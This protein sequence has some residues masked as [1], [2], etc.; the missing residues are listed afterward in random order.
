MKRKFCGTC[1]EVFPIP[2]TF[3]GHVKSPSPTR[4]IET[5]IVLG[6]EDN[7]KLG[8]RKNRITLTG[9]DVKAIFEPVL[10]EVVRLV[11]EQIKASKKDV[12]AVIM[13]GGFSENAYLINAI[14]HA[15]KQYHVE[16]MQC[17]NR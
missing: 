9:A 8:I 16:V 14:T 13:V 2:G 6:L 4:I 11:T 7:E 10:E 17:P 5:R 15:V 3:E 1:E 12:K